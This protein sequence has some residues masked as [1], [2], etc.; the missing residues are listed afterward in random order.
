MI[1]FIKYNS[2]I[3]NVNTVKEPNC[4]KEYN[5]KNK[6]ANRS[7]IA[8]L[9]FVLLFK[10]NNKSPILKKQPN[11]YIDNTKKSWEAEML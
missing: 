4:L 10:M 7:N 5:A 8:I 6:F 9:L 3:N 11:E 1:I 2:K